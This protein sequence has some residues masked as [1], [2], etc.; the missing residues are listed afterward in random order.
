MDCQMIISSIELSNFRCFGE[1]P[2]TLELSVGSTAIIGAN[3]SGKTA[4]LTALRRLFGVSRSERDILRTDFHEQPGLPAGD[5]S[6][7]SLYIEAIFSFP[8]LSDGGDSNAV[9]PTFRHM[10]LGE[11]GGDLTCRI[12]LEASWV[13]DGTSEGAVEQ[14]I[15]WVLGTENPP[16]DDQKKRMSAQ[17]RG[18]IQVHYIP[19]TRDPSTQTRYGVGSG[20]GRLLRAISW[21][22]TTRTS[23]EEA[24]A[25][26][27]ESLDANPAMGLING[28]LQK[29][30]MTLHDGPLDENTRLQFSATNFNQVIQNFEA[31]FSPSE[32]ND[33]RELMNLSDGQQSLFYL[34]LIAAV[35]DVE[36]QH[37]RA[38]NIQNT[39]DQEEEGSG[40][41]SEPENGLGFQTTQ[42]RSPSLT[43]IA[44]EEPE[45][46]L[47]PHYLGRIIDLP[48]IALPLIISDSRPVE[49]WA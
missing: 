47:A 7:R 23:V 8:E 34:A 21:N 31:V 42:M 33:E 5:R 29:R 37:S 18:M 1:S 45:N 30:W 11:P 46:H 10:S 16:P 49:A 35:T 27:Q 32:Q 44:L 25:G 28:L 17:D 19:A 41:D 4:L 24:S 12:R 48:P 36:G 43:I 2:T 40:N 20:M 38:M 15:F 22:D 6:A 3:A 13:D 9:P 26:I 14:E 39:E